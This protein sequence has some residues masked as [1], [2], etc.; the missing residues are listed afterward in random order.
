MIKFFPKLLIGAEILGLIISATGYV[1]KVLHLAGADEMLMIGLMTLAAACFLSGFTLVPVTDDGKPRGFADLL[2][3]ILRK[4]LYIGLAVFLVG[5]LF[6]LLH[7][8]GANEM[9]MMGVG[10]LATGTVLSMALILGNRERMVVLQAPLIRSVVVLVF[11]LV[12]YLR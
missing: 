6:A 9:L 11:S 12:S 7:L 1:F 10:A 2:P 8:E 4:V 3:V 5:F